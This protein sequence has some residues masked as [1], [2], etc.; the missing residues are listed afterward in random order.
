MSNDPVASPQAALNSE[1]RRPRAPRPSVEIA[2][3]WLDITVCCLRLAF[4]RL[5]LACFRAVLFVLELIQ[6]PGTSPPPTNG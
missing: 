2:R 1:P 5:R 4:L 6:R 3:L